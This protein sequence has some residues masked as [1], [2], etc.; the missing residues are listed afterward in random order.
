MDASSEIAAIE[1]LIAGEGRDDLCRLEALTS[2]F[3]PFDAVGM[4]RQ[5]IR[6]S[7]FLEYILGPH[8]PHGLRDALLR[9]VLRQ[10]ADATPGGIPSRIH[11]ELANLDAAVVRREWRGIDLLV[12]FPPG[13][14][15]PNRGVVI[16]IELKIDA[17]EHGDQLVRYAKTLTDSYPDSGWD[18]VCLFLSPGGASPSEE[19]WIPLDLALVINGFEAVLEREGLDG[20]GAQM[21]RDYI[22][23]MR[24]E[25]LS[26]PEVEALAKQIWSKHRDA[27]ETLY[28]YEPDV[29]SDVWDYLL[30][31]KETIESALSDA[32]S[33]QWKL[34]TSDNNFIRLRCTEWDNMPSFQSDAT[35]WSQR[36]SFILVELYMHGDIHAK[37]TLG[38][39]NEGKR[40]SLYAELLNQV[41][42]GNMTMSQRRAS[43]GKHHKKL[44]A[45]RLISEERVEELAQ[46]P[47]EDLLH[48]VVEEFARFVD[49][50]SVG[51]AEAL[52]LTA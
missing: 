25:I 10:V 12:E 20:R 38:P 49:S 31:H 13:S 24:R 47:F 29:W 32:S 17:G 26:N 15:M 44:G 45:R 7:H 42:K 36:G 9:E 14:L 4:T 37:F 21:V 27:L 33:A 1:N 22:A 52:R 41:E 28:E 48:I 11:V 2:V 6:H 3:C 8:R 18:C 51:I 46:E 43:P 34:D 19:N 39:G 23:M 40:H 35:W 30:D 16:A 50:E 5:E